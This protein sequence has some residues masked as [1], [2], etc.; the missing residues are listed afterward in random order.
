M[1]WNDGNMAVLDFHIAKPQ[2][3]IELIANIKP[4]I[5]PG[6]LDYQRVKIYINDKK[7]GEWTVTKSNFH[8]EAIDIPRDYFKEGGLV[9]LRFALPD[10][11]SPSILGINGDLRK[12]ALAFHSVVLKNKSEP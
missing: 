11:E 8:D 12:L 2:S 1:T 6:R 5:A 3:D 10:A 7:V 4:F 9:K